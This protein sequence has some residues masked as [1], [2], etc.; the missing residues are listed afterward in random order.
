MGV[1]SRASLK[2][3]R[4]ISRNA[5]KHGR[6]EAEAAGVLPQAVSPEAPLSH[7]AVAFRL[8]S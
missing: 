6:A 7:G 3:A 4:V 1:I 2:N 5:L 8:C